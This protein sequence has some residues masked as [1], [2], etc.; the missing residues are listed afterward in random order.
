MNAP[1]GKFQPKKDNFWLQI[2]LVVIHNYAAN[3]ALS[4]NLALVK[5]R[6]NSAHRFEF[7]FS[8][9]TLVGE[10]S[11]SSGIFQMRAKTVEKKHT[12]FLTL[13]VMQ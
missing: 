1:N 7:G 6:L 12:Y 13:T 2:Q 5:I 9:A 11:L 10:G 4:S 3:L 8:F